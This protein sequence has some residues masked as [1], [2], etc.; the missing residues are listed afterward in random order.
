M[1]N[2]FLIAAVFLLLVVGCRPSNENVSTVK[3]SKPENAV[4]TPEATPEPAENEIT[5]EKFNRLKTG[6]SY[7]EA[8]E[9]LGAEGEVL[10][11]SEIGGTKTVMYSWAGSSFA[12]SMNAM[13]QNNKL[14]SKAQ[15]GLK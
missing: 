12:S 4:V 9:I 13:F 14:I 10:S 1:K 3:E 15:M 2:L 6:M 5:M 11:E 7:K 8:V